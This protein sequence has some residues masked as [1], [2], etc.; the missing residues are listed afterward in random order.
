MITARDRDGVE[1]RDPYRI[2]VSMVPDAPPEVAVGLSGIGSAVTPQANIP[3]EGKVSDEYGLNEIWYESQIGDELPQRWEI[4]DSYQRRL[5]FS[6]LRSLDLA[7]TDART[8]KP[9]ID[10]Q[11]G[12]QL[13]L[14]VHASDLLRSERFAPHQGAV[15]DSCS[16]S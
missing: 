13:A 6:R 9:L 11:P 3:F 10:V 5:K 1:T 14:S 16:T 4:A 15:N 12:S 7:R 2:V 8:N